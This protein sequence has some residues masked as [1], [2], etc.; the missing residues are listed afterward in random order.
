MWRECNIQ[1]R[2][3][4]LLVAILMPYLVRLFYEHSTLKLLLE[5][6]LSEGKKSNFQ[7]FCIRWF[8]YYIVLKL[9]ITFNLGLNAAENTHLIKKIF[10]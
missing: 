5:I 1:M 8:K 10:K 6:L 4:N 9:Q 7:G 3:V 2:T